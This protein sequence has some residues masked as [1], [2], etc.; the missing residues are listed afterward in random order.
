MKLNIFSGYEVTFLI[1][2]YIFKGLMNGEHIKM[3]LLCS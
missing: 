3:L 1:T 2:L